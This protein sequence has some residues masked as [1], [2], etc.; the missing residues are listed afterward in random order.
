MGNEMVDK[1]VFNAFYSDNSNANMIGIGATEKVDNASEIYIKNIFVSLNS[2]RE[3]NPNID[4]MLITNSNLP[5]QYED[6]FRKHGIKITIIDFTEFQMPNDFIWSYAFYKL[7]ALNFAINNL[8]YKYYLLLDTDTYFA[9]NIDNLWTELEYNQLM[10]FNTKHKIDHS[11][12]SSINKDFNFL[13]DTQCN[14]EHLGGEMIGGNKK[15]LSQF[16]T[17]LRDVYEKVK[18]TGFKID[19]NAGDELFI[20]IA[21]RNMSLIQGGAYLE[22]YW[23]Q[24]FYLCSTN[25]KNDHVCI[26]HLPAEKRFGMIKLFDI[27]IKRGRFPKVE[28]ARKI[29]NLPNG[30]RISLGLLNI[31]FKKLLNKV[32]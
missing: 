5:S 17:E 19:K 7:N 1:L 26:W 12:R 32:T 15:V 25:W 11:V 18:E 4:V 31:Y 24:R 21:A 30:Y 20:S 14:L 29:V 2:A 13:F 22:R 3:Q 10:L 28:R 8:N 6:L 23:T 27:Y 9:R 16:I